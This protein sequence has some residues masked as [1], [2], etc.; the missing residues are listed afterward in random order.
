MEKNKP[1]VIK[2]LQT[3]GK[4]RRIQVALYKQFDEYFFE[5]YT[6]RLVD[7]KSRRITETHNIYSVETFFVMQDICNRFT[8][9]SEIMNK[10]L[11]KEIDKISPYRASTNLK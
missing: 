1:E 10:I 3:K 9:D 6:K 4:N 2:W 5:V 8:K 7:F 11:H